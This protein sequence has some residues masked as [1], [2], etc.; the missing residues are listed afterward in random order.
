MMISRRILV[1]QYQMYANIP[2]E[3]LLQHATDTQAMNVSTDTFIVHQSPRAAEEDS[4]L[5]KLNKN[6]GNKYRELSSDVDDSEYDHDDEFSEDKVI[7]FMQQVEDK[8]KMIS[9]R[10]TEIVLLKLQIEELKKKSDTEQQ[11]FAIL[12][13]MELKNKS[14]A[15][16]CEQ[17]AI[18]GCDIG[19][20]SFIRQLDTKTISQIFDKNAL[21]MKCDSSCVSSVSE[22]VNVLSFATI[23][24]Q[25]KV[26]QVQYPNKETTEMKI[27]NQEIKD[28]VKY[29]AV[30]IVRASGQKTNGKEIN[31]H[32]FK[33]KKE[34]FVAK[35]SEFLQHFVELEA[36][37]SNLICKSWT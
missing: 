34:E 29:I 10:D 20:V 35:V 27:N 15:L 12:N 5:Y 16:C 2:T 9:Q 13:D 19:F 14:L 1:R 17:H 22:L 31:A 18:N 32:D 24:Y 30:C 37:R 6:V 33:L 7:L 26:Y 3:T 23:L 36:K 25:A 4:A 11:H 28:M 21:K 8:D